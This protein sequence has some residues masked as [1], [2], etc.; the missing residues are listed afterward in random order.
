M[1]IDSIPTP[2]PRPHIIRDGNRIWW[3]NK[4]ILE[5]YNEQLVPPIDH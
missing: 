2:F 1:R 5:E 3:L 4:S